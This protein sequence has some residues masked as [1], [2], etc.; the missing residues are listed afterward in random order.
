MIK[1]LISLFTIYSFT[2]GQTPPFPAVPVVTGPEIPV[3]TPA[4]T[5]VEIPAVTQPAV[6]APPLVTVNPNQYIAVTSAPVNTAPV[7]S[8]ST[9][10][11]LPPGEFKGAFNQICDYSFIT[12]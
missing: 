3:V 8:Q 10:S 5:Y 4:T 2:H 12:Q 7:A 9:V 1:T 6:I 11:L